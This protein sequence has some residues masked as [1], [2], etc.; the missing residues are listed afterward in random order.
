MTGRTALAGCYAI[1]RTA[2]LP[3]AMLDRPLHPFFQLI[4][5]QRMH[6]VGRAIGRQEFKET[7]VGQQIILGIVH[8][9]GGSED[10][11]RRSAALPLVT[12]PLSIANVMILLNFIVGP[13]SNIYIDDIFACSRRLCIMRVPRTITFRQKDPAHFRRCNRC[14]LHRVR[15]SFRCLPSNEC[16][17]RT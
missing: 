2:M 17:L 3:L 6:L 10:P 12:I 11:F 8:R 1:R 9:T 13:S 5:G 14:D 4:H 15:G 16:R 7:A